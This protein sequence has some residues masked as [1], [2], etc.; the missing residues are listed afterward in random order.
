MPSSV[1][2]L[3]DDTI[4]R[5]VMNISSPADFQVSAK[6]ASEWWAMRTGHR[7]DTIVSMDV[8]VLWRSST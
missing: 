8:D 2:T 1:T 5:Y 4:A 6:L 7:P 3:F